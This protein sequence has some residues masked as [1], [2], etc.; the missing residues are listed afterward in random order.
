MLTSPHEAAPCFHEDWTIVGGS[1]HD[2]VLW[3][4]EIQLREVRNQL[5][6]EHFELGLA[7]FYKSKGTS[8][9]PLVQSHDA[10][11][12]HP[13]QVVSAEDGIYSVHSFPNEGSEIHVGDVVFWKVQ[14][15][16]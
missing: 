4:L 16:D 9:N 5:L 3:D 13:L 6:R 7:V 8:M 11:T 12:S 15:P 14:P 1:S 10:C 2:P